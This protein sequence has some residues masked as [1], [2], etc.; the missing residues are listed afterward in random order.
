MLTTLVLY[1][2]DTVVEICAER[3]P[4]ARRIVA[5]PEEIRSI[6]CHRH[7]IRLPN[8]NGALGRLLA[9]PY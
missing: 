4:D 9:A 7:D 6:N 1:A 8:G 5:S 3:Q 2:N